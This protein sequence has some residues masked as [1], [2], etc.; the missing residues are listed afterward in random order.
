MVCWTGRTSLESCLLNRH[1]SVHK[2]KEDAQDLMM[3]LALL[4]R[5]E[6][7][8]NKI[9]GNQNFWITKQRLGGGFVFVKE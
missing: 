9:P 8:V 7:I 5:P 1:G 2:L 4:G 3:L 6:S